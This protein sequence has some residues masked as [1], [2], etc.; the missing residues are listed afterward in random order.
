MLTA[1]RQRPWNL[2]C[3][4]SA[5]LEEKM[6]VSPT[7]P[8]SATEEGVQRRTK[9]RF[10][11]LG[12][13]CL[14][15][16]FETTKEKQRKSVLAKYE[17]APNDIRE[18]L[19]YRLASDKQGLCH[20]AVEFFIAKANSWDDKKDDWKGKLQGFRG[21]HNLSLRTA[22]D[23]SLARAIGFNRPAVQRFYDNL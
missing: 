10:G 16:W 4:P 19:D 3:Q 11:K 12:S 17:A 22:E 2:S 7:T 15:P 23:T 14:P 18:G 9:N 1:S 13:H 6:E 20:C 21:H 5:P 8:P